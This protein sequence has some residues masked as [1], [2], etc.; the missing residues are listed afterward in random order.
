MSEPDRVLLQH[1]LLSFRETPVEA[2]RSRADA[3][4]LA[5][6]VLQRARAGE[7]F[8][9]L[10]REFSDDAA[11]ED[12]PQPGLF[13]VLNHGAQGVEDFG[14]TISSLN[15]RA[16][17]RYQELTRRI[18]A[19]EITVEAA[20]QEMEAFIDELRAASDAARARAGFPRAAL[21]PAFGDVG[22]RLQPGEIGLA[23]H[24]EASSPFGWHVIKRLQ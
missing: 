12:D 24:D 6:I 16:E 21:V 9:A 20:E 10:V 8:N 5:Q 18:E 2:P 22:F 1:V 7:D 17:Q 13:L 3:E 15:E 19:G 4:A 23:V 11:P 14:T